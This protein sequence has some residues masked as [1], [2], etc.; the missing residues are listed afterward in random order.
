MDVAFGNDDALAYL[1]FAFWTYKP[2]GCTA[3]DVTRF[4][5]RCGNAE[6]S[7]VGC[8]N[9]DLSCGTDGTENGHGGELTLC[10]DNGNS[11]VACEL[12]GL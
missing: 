3:R 6:R 7:R 11:L 1:N 4:S 5:D 9:L 12:T 10:A 8:G 2:A